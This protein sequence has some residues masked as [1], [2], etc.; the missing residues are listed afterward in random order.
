L[1]Q[2]TGDKGRAAA[3]DD[4]F[5]ALKSAR[6]Q[7]EAD[8]IVA[9]IW[10]LWMQSG[11]EDIDRLVRQAVAL[12]HSSA[13][14]VA[15]GLLDEAVRRAPDYAEAWN[16]RATLLFLMGD[17]ERSKADCAEVLKREPRHFGALAGLGLIGIAQEDFKAALTAFREAIRVNPYLRERESLVPELERRVEGEK[18]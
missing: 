10:E 18:L 15:L 3:L 16:K 11:R 14:P 1:G 17:F 9:E 2:T 4:R 5:A 8:S 13:Q 7:D 12:F 6:S